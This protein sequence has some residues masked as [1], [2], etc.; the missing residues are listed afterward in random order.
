MMKLQVI[1]DQQTSTTITKIEE[2][3]IFTRYEGFLSGT[4][5]SFVKNFDQAS[6]RRSRTIKIII[7]KLFSVLFAFRCIANIFWPNDVIRNL[8]CNGYHYIG[9]SLLFN[10]GSL[11]GCLSGTLLI[12]TV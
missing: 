9:N 11:A 7:L 12:A 2:D 10:L 5:Y 6:E 3:K 4:I 8:T 1:R